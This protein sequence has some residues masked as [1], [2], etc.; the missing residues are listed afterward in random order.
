LVGASEEDKPEQLKPGEFMKVIHPDDRALVAAQL[1]KKQKGEKENLLV[2]YQFRVVNLTGAAKW[3]D[4]Y[5][6]TISF[7][8][9]PAVMVMWMD[10][11]AKKRIEEMMKK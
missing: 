10:I 6:R 8:N 4:H 11:T 5:S 1:S 7:G 2:N 3:I 9:R